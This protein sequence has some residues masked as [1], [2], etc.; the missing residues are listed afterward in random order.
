MG[1]PARR[2]AS[3][4]KS[5]SAAAIKDGACAARNS[6]WA[7]LAQGASLPSKAARAIIPDRENATDIQAL[8]AR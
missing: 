6:R 1:I 5:L 8:D 2:S 7:F 3:G 4:A